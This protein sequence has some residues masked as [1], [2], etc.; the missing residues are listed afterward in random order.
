MAR[1][2]VLGKVKTRLAATIGAENSLAAYR[3][4]LTH[5][6]NQIVGLDHNRFVPT[7]FVTPAE[8][9]S[10]IRDE[11]ECPKLIYGQ[12]GDDLGQ[13]MTAA[14]REL[15]QIQA[16]SRVIVVGSDLPELTS[17]LIEK[18]AALLT[19]VDIVLGPTVDG[20][21]YL[22]GLNQIVPSIFDGI[23]W[24]TGA[25]LEQT[26]Q[27]ARTRE[28]SIGTVATLRDIDT[29]ADY[30]LFRTFFENADRL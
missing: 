14:V 19:E 2:P 10:K 4:L 20:G 29:E 24:S 17:S 3:R 15:F 25:V 13:R 22:I 1:S 16:V 23:T 28:L 5:S 27:I 21:Y 18:A 8:D 12:Q 9:I 30:Q 6:L 7:L 26:I 11:F